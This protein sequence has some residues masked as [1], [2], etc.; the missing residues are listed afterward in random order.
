MQLV[1]GQHN[2]RAWH[3]G[4]AATIGNFDGVHL[5]H[6]AVFNA[7]R[8]RA[9]QLAV[10]ST[11][12]LFE[13]QPMEFFQPQKAPPRLTRLREK[14][15][16][17]R[18][19]GIDRVVL[20]EFNRRLAT[21][22]AEDFV[23]QVL[24]DGL[25]IRHLYVG[26]DFRFGQGRKGDFSLLR[27]MGAE[28]GFSVQG[29]DTVCH[30]DCRISSTRIREAL[31]AGDFSTAKLCLGRPYQI[32]G[33]VGR[34]QQRG[35]TIGFPTLNVNLRRRSSPVQG[36]FAVRVQGLDEGDLPGVANVGTRPTVDGRERPLLEVHLFDFDRQVYGSQ[37]G[38]TFLGKI[39]DERKFSSFE[40]LQQQILL[41]AAQA[42]NMLQ[43]NP[44]QNTGS[45]SP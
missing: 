11:V 25:G 2:L 30:E 12:I 1:R 26:D 16:H 31:A 4:C 28:Q 32:C 27:R 3:K 34:G 22:S 29:L 8:G 38:V 9:E 42:R 10:P 23:Q 13:P 17:I 6:Q 18:N 19:C 14:L 24:V 33:R 40:Q 21:L 45:T 15:V 43:P 39:R 35:R 7:L 37:I 5:G 44:N 41:D 36:V 20:L